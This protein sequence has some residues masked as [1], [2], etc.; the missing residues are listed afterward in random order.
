MFSSDTIVSLNE[1]MYH[2]RTNGSNS[3]IVWDVII[4]MTGW[5][6]DG[7]FMTLSGSLTDM[8]FFCV[9]K[10]VSRSACPALHINLETYF[11]AFPV[12]S[13]ASL[14]MRKRASGE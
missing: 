9:K 3:K 12:S 2:S 8:P 14:R 5:K 10:A 1:V 6:L 7:S 13:N 11:L 4:D